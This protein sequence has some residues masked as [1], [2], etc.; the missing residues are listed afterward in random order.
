MSASL[1]HL[2][3]RLF[4]AFGLDI[5]RIRPIRTR[6]YAAAPAWRGLPVNQSQRRRLPN[7]VA[8][9]RFKAR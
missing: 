6:L 2:V 7:N 1:K 4:S 3:V 8:Q 9:C 5:R